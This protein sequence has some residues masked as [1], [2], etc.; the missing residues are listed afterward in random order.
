[1]LAKLTAST[2]IIGS[3]T[4]SITDYYM[5]K[6]KNKPILNLTSLARPNTNNSSV[7]IIDIKNR[8]NFTSSNIFSDHLI[9]SIKLSL[10]KNEQSLLYLN[11]R[12]TSRLILCQNCGWEA[13][14]PNCNLPLTYH[15][16]H[17]QLRCHSCGYKQDTVP[18]VCP[19]CDSDS[20]IYKTLGTKAIESEI[21]R[22]F[23]TAK[24]ARYDTDNKK[25]DSIQQNYDQ[26]RA[27]G[28]DILIGTQLLAKGF[29]LP[30]L[31]T[32]GVLQADTSLYLPDFSSQERT[33]QLITQVL[34]RVNRGH[35]DSRAII[36][37]YNPGSRLLEQAV[38][39]N[40]NSFY[41]DEL[42]NR[43]DFKFPPYYNLLKLSCRRS[44]PKKAE[45]AASKLKLDLLALPMDIQIDG[46]APAFHEKF[47]H[48]YQ[49]Q[50]VVKSTSRKSLT[51]L[52]SHLPGTWSYDIDPVNLL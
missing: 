35:T 6:E 9:S 21:A 12:G 33:F 42:K 3:A 26:I 45:A 46:P 49:W 32:V 48:K 43:K 40:Y 29:D 11:R 41:L 34:G 18:S 4:P 31:S 27:G 44:T 7:E 39:Q 14:C 16:D 38:N 5:A 22:I 24:V 50:L 2:L 28:I 30:K 15:A 19:S 13:L 8:D 51:D 1:V 20:I 36:Q 23:L 52:I 37:T 47:Q 10:A 17:H 25:A